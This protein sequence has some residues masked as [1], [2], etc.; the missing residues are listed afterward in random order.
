MM[1]LGCSF[2]SFVTGSQLE[3]PSSRTLC[4]VKKVGV[5][6]DFAV[7]RDADG[8]AQR[9][10]SNPTA[11]QSPTGGC[12]SFIGESSRRHRTFAE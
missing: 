2:T 5:L 11:E 9:R 4:I 12:A 1:Q 10:L 7:R 6:S 3:A 8:W